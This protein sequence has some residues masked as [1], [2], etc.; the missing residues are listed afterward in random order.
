LKIAGLKA[1]TY[2]AQA[3]AN[4]TPDTVETYELPTI[5]AAATLPRIV[6]IFQILT[7]QY[8]P[9]EGDPVF[10]GENVGG[11]VPTIIHPNEVFD[12]A[13]TSPFNTMFVETYTIQNHPIIKKLYT[14]HGKSINFSGLI[15]TNAPNNVPEYERASAVAA[16]L[17][18][19]TLRADG[20]ILTKTGGGAPELTMARTAQRCEQMGIKTALA[21]VH[22]GIDASDSSMKANVIFD[23]PEVDAMVSMGAPPI[24]GNITL[25]IPE[26]VIGIPE[27]MKATQDTLKQMRQI[28]G[29][30]SQMGST[31]MTAARY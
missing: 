7:I 26:K 31:K 17:A 18:K 9:L 27:G 29:T 5:D 30:F 15:I 10:Y 1:A 20:A 2:L 4:V 8:V 13:I 22:M 25:P 16:N 19:W 24:S 11:M 6:Y 12:G 14:E 3:G 21:F 28:K 23:A